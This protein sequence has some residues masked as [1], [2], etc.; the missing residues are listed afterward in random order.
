MESSIYFLFLEFGKKK[1]HKLLLFF[2]YSLR[3]F[4]FCQGM[5]INLIT[6]PSSYSP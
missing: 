1:K 5:S 2:K 3:V 4:A 6:I